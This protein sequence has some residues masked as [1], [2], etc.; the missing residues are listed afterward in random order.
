M[1]TYSRVL[2]GV[3]IAVLS[4]I[5]LLAASISSF[6]PTI[7]G[8]GDQITIEGSGFNPG[9]SGTLAV[10]F[11]GVLDT[12]ARPIDA[13][14]TI[15][16]AQVPPGATNGPISVSVNG[17]TPAFSTTDFIVIGPGPYITNFS[18]YAGA[19]TTQVIIE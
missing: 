6:T 10:R 8:V 4:P 7:G 3:L 17:G 19:A 12:T 1:T 5:A 18:P 16:Q 11:N 9:T 13:N 14:G 15:I 2:A